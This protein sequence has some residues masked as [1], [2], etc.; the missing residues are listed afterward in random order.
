M[1]ARGY[2]FQVPDKQDSND[3]VSLAA[4]QKCQQTPLKCDQ[5]KKAEL[6]CCSQFESICKIL[7]LLSFLVYY[8]ELILP[9]RASPILPWSS[10]RCPAPKMETESQKCKRI[11]WLSK[12]MVL[13]HLLGNIYGPQRVPSIIHPIAELSWRE[14]AL[15]RPSFLTIQRYEPK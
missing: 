15:F 8:R 12:Q 2:G 10:P 7:F 1:K 9:I 13:Q 11:R 5:Q 6:K 4:F 14:I 3:L